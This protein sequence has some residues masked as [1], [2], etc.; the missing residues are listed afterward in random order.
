MP[1][2]AEVEFL[3][4]KWDVGLRQKIVRVEWH[5]GKRLFRG[6]NEKRFGPALTGAMYLSSEARAKLKKVRP[7]TFAQAGRISGINPTD[8][9]LLQIHVKRGKAA[10]GEQSSRRGK[11]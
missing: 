7:R 8:I 1:E 3:R 10:A 4:K 11:S 5:R 6:I 9:S 2:L